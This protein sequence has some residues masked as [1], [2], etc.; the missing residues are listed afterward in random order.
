M[1]DTESEDVEMIVQT[2]ANNGYHI[3][4]DE[5]NESG[6]EN[7]RI[8]ADDVTS[9]DYVIIDSYGRGEKRYKVLDKDGEQGI[10][11]DFSETYTEMMRSVLN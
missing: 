8:V 1:I 11:T 10:F 9:E 2:L 6:S 5:Y 4:E 7:W 3:D